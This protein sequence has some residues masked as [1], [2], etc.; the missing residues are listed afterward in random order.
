MTGCNA[1]MPILPPFFPKR[2]RSRDFFFFFFF[3]GS[4]LGQWLHVQHRLRMSAC[5]DNL[6]SPHTPINS[7][8]AQVSHHHHHSPQKPSF[9]ILSC[10]GED[11]DGPPK[12]QHTEGT[13]WRVPFAR[14]DHVHM[15]AVCSLIVCT[16]GT[17]P[18]PVLPLYMLLRSVAN[19][20]ASIACVSTGRT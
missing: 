2:E 1:A 4:S 16:T 13:M 17:P 7:T 5:K 19:N 9:Y 3:F 6:P 12:Q 14:L 10:T 18:T 15:Q 20:H 11:T 8:P